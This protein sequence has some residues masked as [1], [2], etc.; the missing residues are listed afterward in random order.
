MRPEERAGPTERAED[1][2]E[3]SEVGAP[4]ELAE[5]KAGLSETRTPG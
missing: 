2:D 5:G 1:K 3:L 4:K